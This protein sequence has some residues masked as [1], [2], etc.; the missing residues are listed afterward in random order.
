MIRDNIFSSAKPGAKF[1]SLICKSFFNPLLD[2]K[3]ANEFFLNM[4]RIG[5]IGR[6][7]INNPSTSPSPS[8]SDDIP[9]I[10]RGATI[11]KNE[12]E[13]LRSIGENVIKLGRV[14]SITSTNVILENGI[15]PFS[16][17]DT[18]V[19][20][21]IAEDNFYGYL[22]FDENFKVFN[23]N[24]IRLGPLGKL[25]IYIYIVYRYCSCF[26]EVLSF[27]LRYSS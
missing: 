4:E 20:D 24:H 12:L 17:K 26:L 14:T 6:V 8:P 25:Y 2:S 9:H 5:T 23:K 18:L 10:F 22:N 19:V 1:W 3:S 16:S 15:I 11:N 13:N 21:C 27:V 7:D